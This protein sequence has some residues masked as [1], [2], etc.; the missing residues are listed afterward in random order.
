MATFAGRGREERWRKVGQ[1]SGR[2]DRV[3]QRVTQVTGSLLQETESR[4]E[5]NA[6]GK[7]SKI[8]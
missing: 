1:Q 2:N 7:V 5:E 4:N 8:L 3:R 6:V